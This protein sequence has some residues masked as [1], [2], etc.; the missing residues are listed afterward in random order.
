MK[1][2]FAGSI[3]GGRD[4]ASLYAE[5]IKL[6]QRH[7]TVLTEHIGLSTLTAYGEDKSL[8]DIFSR[9]VAWVR[10][11]DVLVAEVTQPSLGVG[12]EIGLA[13][14]LGKKVIC[15]YRPTEGR[16]L[17]AMISGNSYIVTIS[18]TSI[19]ELPTLLEQAFAIP[20]RV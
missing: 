15:L 17:S 13:E 4:D 14:S 18:Y 2:Y 9:D 6:L 19:E 8:A 10:E 11:A 1:I 12:Y 7:G 20:E 16:R 5:V 3:T